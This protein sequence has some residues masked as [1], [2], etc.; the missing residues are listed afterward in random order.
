MEYYS[1][2]ERNEL[3]KHTTEWM[4]LRTVMLIEKK[5]T[6]SQEYILRD[7]IYT[8]LYKNVN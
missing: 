3:L 7:D 4:N 2:R 5:P 6:P 1:T 8:E